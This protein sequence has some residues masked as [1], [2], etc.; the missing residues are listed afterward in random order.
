MFGAQAVMKDNLD[1]GALDVA[2]EVQEKRFNGACI[3]PLSF[4]VF[5]VE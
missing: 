2:V 3:L 1:F 4:T 5:L